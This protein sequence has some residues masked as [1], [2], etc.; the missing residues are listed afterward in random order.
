[1]GKFPKQPSEQG[2]LVDGVGVQETVLKRSQ[3][4]PGQAKSREE[5]EVG[6]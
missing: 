3:A 1:M 6:Q 5:E 2:G 4:G